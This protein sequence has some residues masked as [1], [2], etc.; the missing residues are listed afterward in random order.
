MLQLTTEFEAIVIA[1]W[2][3]VEKAGSGPILR[4]VPRPLGS[5]ALGCGAADGAGL[6]GAGLA[7]AGL[8][9]AGVAALDG[10]AAAGLAGAEADGAA[11]LRLGGRV[12]PIAGVAL[13]TPTAKTTAKAAA[14]RFP[15]ERMN[16]ERRAITK[17]PEGM[18]GIV[19]LLPAFID[20][21][22]GN[23][24]R[25]LPRGGEANGQESPH[26]GNPTR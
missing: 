15:R 19:E 22:Q 17:A 12:A 14:A 21:G 24:Y 2:A 7:G 16:P 5:T 6:A 10:A 23:S 25:A 13:A 3:T 26:R 18:D 11:G 1:P 20:N 4:G 8:A 9:G